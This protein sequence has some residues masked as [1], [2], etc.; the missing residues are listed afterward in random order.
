MY[1]TRQAG[2][3]FSCCCGK[4]ASRFTHPSILRNNC[5]W[6]AE[7]EPSYELFEL[8]LRDEFGGDVSGVRA[9]LSSPGGSGGGADG[10]REAAA[11]GRAA[12]GGG[13]RVTSLLKARNKVRPK[14]LR[15]RV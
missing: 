15:N 4:I 10:D 8:L 12:G 7:D 14:L 5:S 1:C 2:D 6:Q 3:Y 9:D 11:G 13:K